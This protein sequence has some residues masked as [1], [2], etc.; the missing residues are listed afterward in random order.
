MNHD[1]RVLPSNRHNRHDDPLGLLEDPDPD[2]L[3]GT[4]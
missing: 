2:S 3:V 4:A 1:E